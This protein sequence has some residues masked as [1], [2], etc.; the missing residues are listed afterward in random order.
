[1]SP[2]HPTF[3][4]GVKAA[5][6]GDPGTPFVLLGNF[7]V[8]DEWAR[9]EVGLPTVGG[10]ASA[11]IVNR[12]DEFTVLLAGPDDHVVLKS[13][14]DPDYLHWLAGLGVDL[15][16]IL[17]TDSHDPAAT[18]SVDALRSPRLLAALGDLAAR[19]AYLLPHGMS[20]LEEQLCALTGLAPALPPVPVV[21]A[22]NSKIYSR[23]VAADLGLPQATGWECETVEEFAAAAAQAARSVAAGRR[24]GV[25]DAYGVSG[26]GIVVVDDPRRLDQLVRMVTRRA[27]RTGDPRVAL[28]IE[29]WADKA[30]DLNYHF[31][32]GRDGAV[33]F[34]FVKEA[35]TENGVHKG[36]RI[37]ARI[38][39]A[40][41][42][43]I[44]AAA[45]RLGARL[46]ADGFHGVVGVDAI[47]TTDGGL[48]PVLEINA[49]NNM[50]TY[51][52]TLQERFMGADTIATARQYDLTLTG[53]VR[54]ADLRDQLGELLFDPAR[55]SGL[56]VNNFATVNA[57]APDTDDPRPYAGRLYGLLMAASEQEL[58][59]LDRAIV[60]T[61]KKEPAHV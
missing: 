16:R 25:K 35:L 30:L 42:G 33:R 4:T 13:A 55:G 58:A 7:E 3:L 11:A 41:A 47:T 21:K 5:C 38:S 10:R 37:P 9:D 31:T 40:H 49:R 43:Q 15:P 34:D 48:L 27:E 44:M 50:S 54:F 57:A 51:Q 28:V 61:V 53:P 2:P 46:A 23:R 8:E 22:V 36:H 18:V 6:T 59:D 60:A 45:D 26:K 56:L 24:V 1:M 19:G 29:E 20:T 39:A 14:P 32:V 52:T 12:M 17:V